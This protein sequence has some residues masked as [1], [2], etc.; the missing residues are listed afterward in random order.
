[1]QRVERPIGANPVL[2]VREHTTARYGTTA[3]AAA[4]CAGLT[5]NLGVGKAIRAVVAGTEALS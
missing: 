4:P 5:H 3:S 2:L 1:M